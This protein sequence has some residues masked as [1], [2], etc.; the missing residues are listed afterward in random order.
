VIEYNAFAFKKSGS[1][2]AGTD[3]NCLKYCKKQ[4]WFSAKL[5]TIIQRGDGYAYVNG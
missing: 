2:T 4:R 3:K 1:I 5:A